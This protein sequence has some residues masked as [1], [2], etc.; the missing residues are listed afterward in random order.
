M[1]TPSAHIVV[2]TLNQL[3]HGLEWSCIHEEHSVHFSFVCNDGP[4][5][6]LA[7]QLFELAAA[8]DRRP[9]RYSLARVRCR[10][11]LKLGQITLQ[12]RV[13]RKLVEA[14]VAS[15][16]VVRG[17]PDVL[18]AGGERWP[19]AYV[20]AMRRL[21]RTINLE[22]GLRTLLDIHQPNNVGRE[23]FGALFSLHS[24]SQYGKAH[25]YSN[26]I[27][28]LAG[29]S[30]LKQFCDGSAFDADIWVLGTP[31]AVV[32][33]L[34]DQA[35]SNLYGQLAVSI[36]GLFGDKRVAFFPH[37]R[38][39]TNLARLAQD[40][41]WDCA[42]S[43][44]PKELAVLACGKCPERIVGFYSTLTIYLPLIQKQI[45]SHAVF[46]ESKLPGREQLVARVNQHIAT[47]LRDLRQFAPHWLVSEDGAL[48]CIESISVPLES[49]ELDLYAALKSESG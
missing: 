14:L 26:L 2:N 47:G 35:E 28:R 19:F 43:V 13:F 9:D 45:Q 38:Q 4:L 39:Q 30:E 42:D 8:A 21:V 17:R 24:Y 20:R 29:S 23:F 22:D 31:M 46:V 3:L 15:Q 10:R 33:G 7:T 49:K 40:T 16:L 18:L 5:Y 48:Q 32:Y 12:G 44:F 34:D 11:I 25:R 1:P 37:P 41:G 6:R 27:K 36:R